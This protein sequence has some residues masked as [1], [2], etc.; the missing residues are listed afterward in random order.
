MGRSARFNP[1]TRG[2]CDPGV[3]VFCCQGTSFNPRTRGGCDPDPNCLWL[4]GDVSIHAPA[5]GATQILDRASADRFVSIHA[6]AGGATIRATASSH[7]IEF[8][9]THPR[10]VRPVRAARGI[11]ALRFNPRTRGGCDKPSGFH[12]VSCSKFQSTHPRGVRQS[13]TGNY[14]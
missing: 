1:R 8:Q 6:P 12:P 7:L 9:S 2:G 5:G 10:G 14:S 13:G 3:C 11:P 4:T